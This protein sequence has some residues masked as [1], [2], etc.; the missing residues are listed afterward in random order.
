MGR[1]YTGTPNA[2]AAGTVKTQLAALLGFINTHVGAAAGAHN[3]SAIA[4]TVH[5]FI[6]A[7]NVQSQLQQIVSALTSTASPSGASRIGVSDSTQLNASD[8]EGALAEM[9][10]A[11]AADH[12][13]GNE[14]N[15]GLHKTIRQ[16][17]LGGS[18]A[19]LWD[20][21]GTGGAS[22]RFRVYAD[23]SSIWFTMN[24]SWTG[25]AWTRD[26]TTSSAGGF[27]F[28][29]VDFETFYQPSGSGTFTTWERRW[30]LPMVSP[31][32]S[33]FELAGPTQEIGRLGA[34]WSNTANSTQ[35]VAAGGSSTFRNRFAATPS[36]ITLS[37]NYFTVV[38]TAP[39]VVAAS[40]DG[41][42]YFGYRSLTAGQ[43]AF[44]MG[45]Y[46]ATA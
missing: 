27:R 40:R 15:P 23:T 36:S 39:Q 46:T 19:L 25:S 37:V 44:W 22:A 42:G 7:T 4:A 34:A 13:R 16:P 30:R 26:S 29:S 18:K 6:S 5:S 45:S 2:L 33:A 32:N 24:A 38:N 3:A 31:T 28:S 9:V 35:T 10:S 14:T 12:Q 20:S 41:F 1:G 8:V 21:L 43:W 17:N 11:F